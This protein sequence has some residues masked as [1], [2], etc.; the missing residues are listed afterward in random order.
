MRNNRDAA[1]QHGPVGEAGIEEPDIAQRRRVGP[2]RQVPEH[3]IAR[4]LHGA[5]CG[6]L[7]CGEPHARE[8]RVEGAAVD[9]DTPLGVDNRY[10]R[11]ARLRREAQD[12]DAD[13]LF[14]WRLNAHRRETRVQVLEATQPVAAVFA[15]ILDLLIRARDLPVLLQA[16]RERPVVD[17]HVPQQNQ[18]AR[19][20]GPKRPGLHRVLDVQLQQL[21]EIRRAARVLHDV[22]HR[23]IEMHLQEHDASG[24]EVDEVVA[25][26]GAR[27]PGD[28][29]RI[30]IDEANIG[31]D[32][33]REQRAADLTHRD[34]ARDAMLDGA[35]GDTG[36]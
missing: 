3:R 21:G 25:E 17:L 12:V 5:A 1:M 20:R 22:D 26:L 31:E 9:R 18:G 11:I 23:L 24:R 2:Q 8:I 15:G 19:T 14:S 16:Q 34:R 29:R 7:R 36:E 10:V 4:P 6:E 27:Q 33:S 13:A 30:G 28:Q 35:G 32:D